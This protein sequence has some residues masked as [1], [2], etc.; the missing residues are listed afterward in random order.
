MKKFMAGNIVGTAFGILLFASLLVYRTIHDGLDI[1]TV[2]NN[3]WKKEFGD[4]EPELKV[5]SFRRKYTRR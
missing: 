4:N 3:S 5:N 2:I 1:T